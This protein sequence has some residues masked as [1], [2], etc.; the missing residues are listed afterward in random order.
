M[1]SESDL[2]QAIAQ[3]ADMV[4]RICMVH[5]KNEYD[6][7]DVFQDVFF[8]YALSP[9]LFESEEHKKAWLIRVTLNACK[10]VF[11]NF[12]RKLTT[13]L[14][15]VQEQAVEEKRDD[16]LE[17]LLSLEAKYKDVLYLHYY[18]GYTAKKI[19][20]LL[21]KNENTIYT[22]LTRGREK[23]KQRLEEIENA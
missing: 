1:R 23:L 8:K 7:Q 13:P 3:Y 16:L 20:Q 22:Y 4:K 21:H 6:T 14:E 19:A 15:S 9:L 10:D 11:K 5:L 17:V 2:N 18:E 12:F